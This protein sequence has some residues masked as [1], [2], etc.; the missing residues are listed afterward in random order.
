MIILLISNMSCTE[1]KE[2]YFFDKKDYISEVFIGTNIKH[3]EFISFDLNGDTVEKCNYR[4][5]KLNGKYKLY[6]EGGNSIHQ[7][8]NYNKGN[9]DGL[10]YQYYKNGEICYILEYRKNRIWNINAYFDINGKELVNRDFVEGQGFV[11]KYDSLGNIIEQGIIRNGY[12]DGY[13]RY[14]SNTGHVDS[15]FYNEGIIKESG[16]RSIIF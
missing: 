8:I 4:F 12:K 10:F 14:I 7:L 16:L 11:N 13:W 15:V 1:K 6:Y 2:Y 5:N 9:I 3:G